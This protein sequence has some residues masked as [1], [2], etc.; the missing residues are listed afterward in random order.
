MAFMDF[1]MVRSVLAEPSVLPPEGRWVWVWAYKKI[2]KGTPKG[3]QI[4]PCTLTG[5]C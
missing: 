2:S 1:K 5:T 3:H 4:Q